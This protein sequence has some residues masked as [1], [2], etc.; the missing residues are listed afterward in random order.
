MITTAIVRWTRQVDG[1]YLKEGNLTA[2]ILT[3]RI[4]AIDEDFE[5]NPV[6]VCPGLKIR[7]KD[8]AIELVERKIAEGS[9]R[10]RRSEIRPEMFSPRSLRPGQWGL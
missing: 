2:D 6:A 10:A 7:P 4:F 9:Y 5:T 3:A 8:E 1:S